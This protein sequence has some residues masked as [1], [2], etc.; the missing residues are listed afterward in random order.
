MIQG[1]AILVV[2]FGN[3]STKG[4]V[5][6][7][8]VGAT[9]RYRKAQ[10]EVPNAFAPISEDYQISSDYSK[11]NSTVLKLSG[12]SVGGTVLDGCFCNGEL[13]EREFPQG[14]IRP[15]AY[16]KKYEMD[17]T[18]LSVRLAFF[19]AYKV[20]MKMNR[21]TDV[22]EV[23]VSWSVVTLLPPGD[24]DIGREPMTELIKSVE[25]I[26]SVF[27]QMYTPVTVDKVNVF[28]EGFC[29]YVA[30]A[31]EEGQSFRRGYEYL[32][33]ETVLIF[34]IGAGTT[35]CAVVKENKLVQRSKFTVNQ[36]GNNVLQGVRRELRL[37]GLDLE[38]EEIRSG[39]LRGYVKDGAKKVDIV[40]LANRAKAE[41]ASKIVADF[42]NY[43]EGSDLNMRSISYILTCGGGSM[44]DLEQDGATSL[45]VKILESIKNLAPN[46]ELIKLPTQTVTIENPD[47]TS[48]K[49]D[50]PISARFL[51]LIGASILA[52]VV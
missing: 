12:V 46:A 13:Q 24:I 4:M 15:T 2:D 17:A 23:Q 20:L 47:G 6:F 1:K 8:K 9:G 44:Q 3:S 36:G 34:D 10:F 41:V 25:S 5:L 39:I 18:A 21:L 7:G 35:D 45:S 52:E 42:I 29:G 32:C 51:N 28:A 33:E 40:E 11:E 27:P 19:W 22:S 14:I 43:L 31:Y 30:C 49:A 37:I 50:Q 38:M 26:E 48:V 16:S